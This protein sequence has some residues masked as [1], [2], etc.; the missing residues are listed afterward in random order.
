MSQTSCHTS[1]NQVCSGSVVVTAYDFES[2][3]PGSNPEW[4]LGR[5]RLHDLF[6]DTLGS[7][8]NT[9]LSQKSD[10]RFY[11]FIYLFM[12]AWWNE[13]YTHRRVLEGV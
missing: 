5:S 13:V 4:V 12:L 11:L 1:I 7:K 3:R 6:C 10:L 2:G 9:I 8:F